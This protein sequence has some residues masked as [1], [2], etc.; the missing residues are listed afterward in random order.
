MQDEEV[1]SQISKEANAARNPEENG[2]NEGKVMSEYITVEDATKAF[3]I[4]T[5]YQFSQCENM[6]RWAINKGDVQSVTNMKPI[7]KGEWMDGDA[8][9]P[10]CGENKFKGLD[11]DIWADW[12]P[13]FCP[14]CG[15]E[16]T[17][18]K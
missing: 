18:E 16:M 12:Q 17:K 6:L 5:V 2:G 10:V 4:Q 11:A 15:A 8:N 3:G 13:P 9:C 7:V 14:N 1:E